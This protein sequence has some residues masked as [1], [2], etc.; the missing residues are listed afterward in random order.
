MNRY[1]PTT[2]TEQKWAVRH[3]SLVGIKFWMAVKSD[4]IGLVLKDDADGSESLCFRAIMEGLVDDN[5]DV[6][7]VSSSSLIPISE[8][9]IEVVGPRLVF[10]RIVLVRDFL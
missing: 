7:A 8:K 4:L 10:N 1:H 9:L 6:R 2:A 3:A 5:D